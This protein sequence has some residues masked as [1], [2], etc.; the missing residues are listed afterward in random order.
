MA[1]EE[2][3]EN[4]PWLTVRALDNEIT[5]VLTRYNVQSLPTLFLFDKEG[6]VQGRYTDFTAL[7]ADI[8]KYL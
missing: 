7:E 2:A 1:W 3:T 6:N 8:N 4:L 5:E